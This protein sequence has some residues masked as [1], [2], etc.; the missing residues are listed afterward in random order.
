MVLFCCIIIKCVYNCVFY[1]LKGWMFGFLSKKKIFV[2]GGF[3]N[4]LVMC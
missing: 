2:I 3:G 4:V 1:V